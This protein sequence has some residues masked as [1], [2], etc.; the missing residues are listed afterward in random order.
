M[1]KETFRT[2]LAGSA[3]AFLSIVINN[4]ALLQPLHKEMVLRV[5]EK[6]TAIRQDYTRDPL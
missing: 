4:Y 2:S 3:Y 5:K 6:L 1:G